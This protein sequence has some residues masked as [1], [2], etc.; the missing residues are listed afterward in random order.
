MKKKLSLI[1]IIRIFFSIYGLNAK[2]IIVR[3]ENKYETTRDGM[4]ILGHIKDKYEF[5]AENLEDHLTII[6]QNL[7][8][9]ERKN[10]DGTTLYILLSLLFL[11]K[12]S[13]SPSREDFKGH[14]ERI[15]RLL[16]EDLKADKMILSSSKKDGKDELFKK[17]I[18]TVLG[19]HPLSDNLIDGIGIENF[20]K[21]KD[22]RLTISHDFNGEPKISVIRKEGYKIFNDNLHPFYTSPLYNLHEE[23]DVIYNDTF[24]THDCAKLM[25]SIDRPII[26]F[27]SSNPSTEA[28]AHLND[29]ARQAL[30][31]IPI[32]VPILDPAI[33]T[34]LE[35]LDVIG[36]DDK[37]RSIM[38]VK[39]NKGSFVFDK[40]LEK[41]EKDKL[42]AEVIKLREA[43]NISTD[44]HQ[45]QFS[46][47][48]LSVCNPDICDM[49]IS[50]SAPTEEYYSDIYRRFEDLILS[51]NETKHIVSGSLGFIKNE[52]LKHEFR[53]LIDQFKGRTKETF[54]S[55]EVL[56]SMI[57]TV[58]NSLLF[59]AD[60][61]EN[62]IG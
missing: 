44:Y 13:T 3:C 20:Y 35:K 50:I 25:T 33:K 62:I 2:P 17:H 18:R 45:R 29:L 41:E 26:V 38:N 47:R 55:Y 48:V 52:E 14:I 37:V 11:N 32:V 54:D 34:G 30:I 4:V 23:I 15:Q 22:A 21:I 5:D 56:E 46:K 53:S 8:N 57:K 6:Y 12:L 42:K 31:S 60:C 39:I 43:I 9:Y 19:F 36:D 10:G 7:Q 24:T 27:T 58:T 28:L 61:N 49:K 1:D 40:K 59:I 51:I 16:L